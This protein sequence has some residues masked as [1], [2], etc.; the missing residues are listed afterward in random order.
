MDLILKKDTFN[1]DH[2]DIKRGKNAK[3]II[4]NLGTLFIIGLPLKIE[5]HIIVNQSNKYL[6]IDIETSYDKD[7]LF[8]IDHYFQKKYNT[9]KSFIDNF[10]IKIKKHK[11]DTIDILD[12]LYISINNIKI[13]R[14]FTRL[15][16]FTI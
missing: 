15:Q 2:I 13:E 14:S 3:K 10:I 1:T 4:Y 6:F 9:Y 7:L 8:F 16:I 11:T 5:N 12:D